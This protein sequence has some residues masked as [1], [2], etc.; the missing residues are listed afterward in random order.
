MTLEPPLASASAQRV[1][2]VGAGRWGQVHLLRWAQLLGRP[3]DLVID[4]HPSPE[5]GVSDRPSLASCV[6]GEL[7]GVIA[8]VAVPIS[9]LA[10]VSLQLL[11]AGVKAILIEKPGACTPSELA[12]IQTRAREVGVKVA[13]GY[14]ERFNIASGP[15]IC[16]LEAWWLSRAPRP[17]LEIRRSGKG[18]ERVDRPKRLDLWCHDVNLLQRSARRAGLSLERSEL[19]VDERGRLSLG[20]VEIGAFC[21]TTA[22]GQRSWSIGERSYTLME[23]LTSHTQALDPLSLECLAFARWVTE[24][25][26][27]TSLC[28]LDEAIE[29][30]SALTDHR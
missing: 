11:E 3:V 22:P 24:G 26:W 20:G 10:T 25:V 12:T 5:V 13:V 1:V 28:A 18:E 30:L 6:E 27:S 19:K 9:S 29:T 8:I 2:V 23:P 16:A 15:L 14:I 4:P 21:A 7:L 17:W